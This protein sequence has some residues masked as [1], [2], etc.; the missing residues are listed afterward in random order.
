MIS[1]STLTILAA[2]VFLLSLLANLVRKNTTLLGLYA[3]QSA[4]SAG[5]LIMLAYSEGTM[6]LFWAGVLTLLVKAIMAPAFLSRM[7]SRYNAHFSAAS[8][9]NTPLSLLVI[10]TLTAFAYSFV[11]PSFSANSSPSISLLLSAIFATLFLMINR[12]GVLGQIVGILALENAVVLLAA[13]LGLHQSLALELAIAFDIAVW[14]AIA[15]IFLGMM[16]RQ[17]GAADADTLTMRHLTEE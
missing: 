17:F 1:I 10:A 2:S 14:I 12:R 7:I 4:I 13:F 16:Y 5:A 3:L 11:S 8:H 9:L 15:T 6:G